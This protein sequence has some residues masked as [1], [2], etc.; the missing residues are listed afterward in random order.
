MKKIDPATV[1][2]LAAFKGKV[3][4]IETGASNN[5]SDGMWYKAAQGQVDLNKK[6]ADGPLNPKS[7]KVAKPAREGEVFY[8]SAWKRNN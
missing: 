4:R 1:A 8:H 5:V 3:T 2:A 7:K 6:L